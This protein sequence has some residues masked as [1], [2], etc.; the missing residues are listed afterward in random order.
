MLDLILGPIFDWFGDLVDGF[1]RGCAPWSYVLV[2][3]LPMAMLGGLY[4][5]LLAP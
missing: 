3:L 1:Y 2:L 5:L 4:W